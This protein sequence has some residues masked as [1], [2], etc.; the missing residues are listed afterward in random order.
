[1]NTYLVKVNIQTGGY[2]KTTHTM[3]M[4]PDKEKASLQALALECH[5]NSRL[6]GSNVSDWQ[7]W[8]AGGELCYTAGNC[9]RLFEADVMILKKLG[10]NLFE[11]DESFI[12]TTLESD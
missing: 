11:Y 4:A 5:G 12:A 2:E 10:F 8:G 3:V 6:E 9:Q 1:M 7:V